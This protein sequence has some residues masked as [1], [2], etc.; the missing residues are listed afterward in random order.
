M[1]KCAQ[2]FT[3]LAQFSGGEVVIAMK[4]AKQTDKNE[5]IINSRPNESFTRKEM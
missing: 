3:L 4:K 1:F 2:R 5:V